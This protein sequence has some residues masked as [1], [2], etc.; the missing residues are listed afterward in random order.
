[1]NKRN[2]GG[3]GWLPSAIPE[4]TGVQEGVRPLRTTRCRL[5]SSWVPFDIARHPAHTRDDKFVSDCS[6]DKAVPIFENKVSKTTLSRT[7]QFLSVSVDSLDPSTYLR[8]F[9][10]HMSPKHTFGCTNKLAGWHYASL[11]EKWSL[12]GSL[13]LW[14]IYL[15]S[16]MYRYKCTR[17]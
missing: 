9:G 7:I 2:R 3:D 11:E 13:Y 1:M 17:K 8:M 4:V 10:R 14:C 6:S 12:L 16:I 15:I 5:Q